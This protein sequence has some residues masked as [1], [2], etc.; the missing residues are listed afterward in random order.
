PEKFVGIAPRF[1][2]TT[3]EN[4]GQIVMGGGS[5]TNTSIYLIVWGENTCHGIYPKG[6]KGGLTMEDKGQVTLEDAAGGKYEG[7][8]THYKWDLGLTVRDWRY[9]VRIANINTGNLI[10]GS[11]AA[12]LTKLMIAA[13]ELIPNLGAGRAAFYCNRLVRTYLRNQILAKSNVNLSFENVGGKR[14]T[15]FDGIPVRRCD[16]ILSTEATIV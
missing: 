7:Y 16:Q 12:D 10:S 15:A 3:A 13:E 14:I 5:A 9:V 6:S 2:L 8:R 1:D 4:G 11:S